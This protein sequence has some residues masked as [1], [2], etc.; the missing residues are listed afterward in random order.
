MITDK[1]L[2]GAKNMKVKD[3]SK[4]GAIVCTYI[5]LIIVFGMI[6]SFLPGIKLINSNGEVEVTIVSK[7]YFSIVSITTLGFGDI[8]P[9]NDI[10]RII[11]SFEAISGVFLIGY[12]FY[13]LANIHTEKRSENQKKILIN[14]AERRFELLKSNLINDLKHL[15]L[16]IMQVTGQKKEVYKIDFK[17][18]NLSKLHSMV[19]IYSDLGSIRESR[20]SVFFAQVRKVKDTVC[21]VLDITNIDLVV[22]SKMIKEMYLLLSLI[23]NFR[24]ESQIM[25][26]ESLNAGTEKMSKVVE[27]AIHSIDK[28]DFNNIPKSNIVTPYYHFYKYI[29]ELLMRI[30]SIQSKIQSNTK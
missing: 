15:N 27:E 22:D 29:Q 30:L 17:F 19:N 4:L 2:G 9:D 26:V 5:G 16:S 6:Y 24:L 12:F 11:A 21:N 7:I 23:N 18:N 8:I 20:V 13:S 3:L 25:V 10:T 14:S 28:P 1:V